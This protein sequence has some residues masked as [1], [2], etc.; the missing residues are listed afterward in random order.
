[1]KLNV[2]NPDGSVETL[3]VTA[4][5]TGQEVKEK[6]SV[7]MKQNELVRRTS[8]AAESVDEGDSWFTGDFPIVS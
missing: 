6:C 7:V 1:M 2:T 3:E 5:A 4:D 8:A